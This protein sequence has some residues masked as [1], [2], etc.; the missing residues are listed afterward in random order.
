MTS[1]ERIAV[2]LRKL[3]RDAQASGLEFIADLDGP[4]IRIVFAED[5]D[6]DDLRSIAG[7]RVPFPLAYGG[8]RGAGSYDGPTNGR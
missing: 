3:H 6:R 8:A 5:V 2:R 4:G 7:V 1:S